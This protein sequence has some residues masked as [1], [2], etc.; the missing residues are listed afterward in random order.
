MGN[1]VSA[2]ASQATVA[3]LSQFDYL[4]GKRKACPADIS[5]PCQGVEVNAA[6]TIPLGPLF[7]FLLI[8]FLEFTFPS[9]HGT[10]V[11]SDDPLPI[12]RSQIPSHTTLIS[13]GRKLTVCRR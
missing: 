13:S 4:V 9:A 11:A 1:G 2:R 8:L 5:Q 10:L 7:F 6:S 3:T 12:C